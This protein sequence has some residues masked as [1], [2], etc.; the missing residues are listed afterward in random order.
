MDEFQ[1]AAPTRPAR[2]GDAHK[3]FYQNS[4][5]TAY[6]KDEKVLRDI[7]NRNCRARQEEDSI[8]LIIFYRSPKISTLVMK[9][10]LSQDQS[11][12]K[13]TNVVYQFNCPAGDCAH[14]YNC[15]YV[16]HTTTSLSRRLS[17]HLQ[18]GAPEKH[19]RRSHNS[20][21]TRKMLVDNT[22][23]L[24]RCNNKKKLQ[25]LEAVYI[26][27]IDPS[28]NRQMNLCSSLS[29]YDSSPLGARL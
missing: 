13:S 14:R 5:S 25:V 21:L 18:D 16:G 4:T 24:A 6:A 23:I 28:I 22:A 19:L 7:V 10:N 12:L 15:C 3:L 9:N 8:Q 1:Q 20:E 29:L 27:D 11:K 17:M 26:R 2:T